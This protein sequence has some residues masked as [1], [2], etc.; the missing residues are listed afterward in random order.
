MKK[1]DLSQVKRVLIIRH[2]AIGDIILVTPFI[3][4]I[5]KALPDAEIDMLVEPMGIEIL[6][7]NPYLANV[8]VYEKNRLKKANPFVKIVETVRFY[9]KLF[10]R[11]YDLVFDLWGN[12]RTALMSFL[13]GAKYRVGFHFRI[14][15]YLYNIIVVPDEPPK[16]NAYF[17]MDQ[18]KA[19]GIPDDGEKADF[20][21]FPGDIAFADDF[22]RGIGVKAGDTV[23]GLNGAG[24]WKTKRWPEHK[25][26]ELADILIKKHSG[27]KIVII[28][29]PSEKPMAEKIYSM[30]KGDRS[31][32]F[33]T[34]PTTL[35]QLGAVQKRM[36]AFISN[37]G[38]PNHLAIALD[39]PS[40]TVFGPTNY[41]SWVP[42]GNKRHLEVHSALAC[43][44][45]DKMQ[46]P[47]ETECMEGIMPDAVFDRVGQLLENIKYAKIPTKKTEV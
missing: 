31:G 6:K 17:H 8:V 33:L 26:A 1:V 2:K 9:M 29:G 37:D 21:I 47:T 3:R 40:V 12:L 28:W 16:Y 38:A 13:T 22:Y 4:A 27:C 14:R 36:D 18:L 24:T 23:F 15:K 32:V 19:L 39:V 5:K 34:P 25:F 10:G 43:A 44:P 20:Y 41:I 45:C 30:I 7:G 35:K 46:C 11:R 42:A